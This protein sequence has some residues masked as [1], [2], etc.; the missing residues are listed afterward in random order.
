MSIR[1]ITQWSCCLS[2]CL[3]RAHL[4][5]CNRN[6]E[7]RR[8]R[9]SPFVVFVVSVRGRK[10]IVFLF[11]F[12]LRI[13]FAAA[14]PYAGAARFRARAERGFVV[15]SALGAAPLSAAAGTPP[16]PFP[17]LVSAPPN[18]PSMP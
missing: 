10:K 6:V 4:R 14:E 2:T 11:F 7:L 16:A 5:K 8:R 3:S 15:G 12:R 18:T 1:S 13:T 9:T 17:R